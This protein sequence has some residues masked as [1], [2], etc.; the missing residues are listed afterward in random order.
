MTGLWF[1]CQKATIIM[2]NTQMLKKEA[3]YSLDI[4]TSSIR[5]GAVAATSSKFWLAL[6]LQ[7][8]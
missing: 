7:F 2:A 8:Q 5:T 4:K 6:Y 1:K 3:K